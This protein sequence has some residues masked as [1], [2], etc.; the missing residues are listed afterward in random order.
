[1]I[2]NKALRAYLIFSCL[3]YA[4]FL[5]SFAESLSSEK[6]GNILHKQAV[7]YARKGAFEQAL[8]LIKEALEETDSAP[9]VVCDY[10]VILVWSGQCQ[11]AIN[12]YEG[13]SPTYDP[14]DYVLPEVAKCYRIIGEYDKAIHLYKKYLGA[15]GAD[16][17]ATKG[18]I[19]T[20]LDAG[21]L[22]IAR[23]Y[24]QNKME[25]DKEKGERLQLYLAD[26]LLREKKVNDAEAIYLRA[27]E[28]DPDNTHAQLGVSR[29]SI[30]KKKYK[31]AED[32]IE[33]IL[34][35]HPRNIEAL[36]CKGELLE[37][38]REYIDAYKLY[39]K[40]LS[41]YPNSQVARN[42]KYRV[43]MNMGNNSLAREKLEL[44][45]EQIDHEIHQL[46]WGNE[47]M[48]RIWWREPEIALKIL[49]RNMNYAQID[50]GKRVYPV[51][52]PTKFLLRT[53]YDRI[54]A[55][56]QKEDME[57]VV[58]E[59][60]NLKNMDVKLPPWV[61]VN[62][63]DAYLYLQQPEKA[64][65]L[66][67]EAFQKQWDPRYGSTRMSIYYTLREL[68]RYKEAAGILEQL[69]KE[70]PVRII[71][72]GILKDNWRKEEIA[73]NRGWWFLY[74]DRLAEAQKYLQ[75]L[76]YRAPFN[77]HIRTALAHTYLWRGW[78]RLALEEFEIIYTIDP[79]DVAGEIGYCYALNENDRGEEARRIA[80]ELI[81]KYPK[82]RHGQH[83]NRYFEVQ[84][85]R[86][87]TLDGGLT[88]E[89]PGV[90][91]TY[92]SVRIDQPLNPWRKIFIK[93]VWRDISQRSLKEATR[94]GV[95]GVDWRLNRDWWFIGAISVDGGGNN[96][97][98]SGE[99]TF[100]PND[101]LSFNCLY[102][103]YSLFIP[104]RA[105]VHG[106]EAEQW[107]FI[108]RY[109]QGESFLSEGRV[110]LYQ[111]SD[112][113]E[114]WSYTIRLDKALLTRAYWKTRLALE[115]YGINNS[116]TDVPYFSPEYLYSVYLV[117]MVEHVWYKRYKKAL[118]DRL[119]VGLG[120]QWQKGFSA[121]DIW[122]IRY[123]Q[124]Y[125]LS[126]TLTFLL[127]TTYSQ[128]NY[129]GEDTDVLNFYITIKKNF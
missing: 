13:F 103:S 100:N 82:N 44:S 53:H 46:L 70:M 126:D 92:W 88:H 59:Y 2:L 43:L 113:N 14:P 56:R 26:I 28:K 79:K 41:I 15:K 80:K 98:Y 38:Q 40:I 57:E 87:F 16:E 102:D 69:D 45:K 101:Y 8:E 61:V 20:Y 62:T 33:K 66:Y 93:Y 121:E 90:H 99:I 47:A 124:D 73:Y 127:G 19:Y 5:L 97:G 22:D 107:R 71:D 37:A 72:R 42:L 117:P 89:H 4:M 129:D 31:E 123:E 3:I 116:K 12:I 34:D 67:K 104:L 50:T 119:Y 52:Y 65:T 27:F 86:T 55:L 35:K 6:K 122:Y 23:Q 30:I 91:G 95:L 111:M 106:V 48:V 125:R 60:E 51:D 25:K 96:F 36:F 81:K 54:L 9:E 105:R 120:T 128:Q 78:P 17:Q 10:I 49:E 11:E 94:R 21:Q 114:Q 29:I 83:L 84:D 76:L 85:I 32:I 24:V 115:G 77:T 74:Q 118:V 58:Q 7:R 39:E 1:M 64:L 75:Q 108:Q 110:S 109:R 63:A 68:G 18:L 112:N